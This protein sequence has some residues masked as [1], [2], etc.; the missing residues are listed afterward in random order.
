MY[1]LPVSTIPSGSIPLPKKFSD[2]PLC[3]LTNLIFL[4][5]KKGKWYLFQST[6]SKIILCL[7]FSKSNV[8]KTICFEFGSIQTIYFDF[9]FGKGFLRFPMTRK[10]IVLDCLASVRIVIIVLDTIYQT[11]S[12]TLKSL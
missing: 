5:Y 7:Q 4:V 12:S 10:V 11:Y 1:I 9:R 6:F 2:T 8:N 3:D